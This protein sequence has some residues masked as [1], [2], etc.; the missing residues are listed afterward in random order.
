MHMYTYIVP[1][2]ERYMCAEF[3]AHRYICSK[4]SGRYILHLHTIIY[5]Y[6]CTD[7]GVSVNALRLLYKQRTHF[8]TIDCILQIYNILH[9]IF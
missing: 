3:I 8:I 4:V 7:Y 5:V 1:V 9:T 2:C 6:V